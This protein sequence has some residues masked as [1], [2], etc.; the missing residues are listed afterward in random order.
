MYRDFEKITGSLFNPVLNENQKYKEKI[1]KVDEPVV[2][3]IDIVG[4]EKKE[5]SNFS[6]NREYPKK[7]NKKSINQSVEL[8]TAFSN[9]R[10]RPST[11]SSPKK[12]SSKGSQQL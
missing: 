3:K 5:K 12:F 4:K 8:K 9:S 6:S 7:F 10:A 11:P 2:E 1:K